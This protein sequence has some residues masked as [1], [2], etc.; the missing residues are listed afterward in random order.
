M[1]PSKSPFSPPRLFIA[2]AL[3]LGITYY[4]FHIPGESSLPTFKSPSNDVK[5]K[6]ELFV[7]QMLEEEVDGP[8]NLEPLAELC[9][10]KEQTPGL[11][12]HCKASPGGMGN[13]RNM[14]LNCYRFAIEAGGMFIHLYL[15]L[16]I[17]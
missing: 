4:L 17:S 10:S 1:G 15:D 9:R 6:K 14:M 2:L 12:V 3:V 11:I 13:V 8:Y 7:E 5:S 16:D